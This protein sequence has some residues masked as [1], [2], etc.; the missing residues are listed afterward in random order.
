L[1]TEPIFSADAMSAALREVSNRLAAARIP[2]RVPRVSRLIRSFPSPEE[3][4]HA[5]DTYLSLRGEG[6][7][8][9]GFELY[10]NGYKDPTGAHAARNVDLE[11]QAV[12]PR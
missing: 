6:E 9:A 5:I 2:F 7:S 10:V 12:T 11:R 3:A 1:S 4:I 8:W